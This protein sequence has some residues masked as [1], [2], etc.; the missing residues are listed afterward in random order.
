MWND[1]NGDGIL[2]VGEPGLL[3]WSVFIDQNSDGAQ[4]AG[5]PGSVTDGAGLYS[6]PSVPIGANLVRELPAIGWQPTAPGTGMQ[7][8]T[9][10]NGSNVA[11][12]NFGNQ[13]RT[14]GSIRGVA[15]ADYNKNHVR[16]VGEQG[17]AG[18]T[19]FLDTNDN[20]LLDPAEP[21]TLT[22]AD[23][24]YT[25]SLD[26]AGTY[27]FTHLA[28]GTYHVRE[29]VPALL[30]ATLVGDREVTVDLL[31]GEDRTGVNF[32][33]RFRG[34]EIHGTKYNDLNRNH[35]RDAGEPG[36]PGVTIYLD[37][38][39]DAVLNL[40]EP[41]TVTAADGSYS[42]VT[43]LNPGAY[44]LRE[45]IPTG[46][47]QTYPATTGGTLW[48]SGVS[49]AP[50]GNVSPTSITAVLSEFQSMHQNVSLTLP[51]TGALT[52]KIDVF[53]L[54]DD[55]GSFTDN[56]PIVRQRSRRSSAHCKHRCPGL[57]SDSASDASRNTRTSPRN[58]G[59][60]VRSS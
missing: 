10:P 2:G 26:E 46:W 5:E 37:M 18:I 59:R 52:N 30:S 32:A 35:Q 27:S 14:D 58:T 36:I 20:G 6:I 56:S 3:G 33:M 29:I 41:R 1:L 13:Q 47:S 23:L 9:V 51:S 49:N 21:Q 7:L 55:T 42:F 8:V 43:N 31:S 15:Y 16:D 38:N 45:V 39:R 53:L 25:P 19:V 12:V 4:N 54:F 60:G 44:V 48:P 28:A 24:F 50:I 34:N 11:G 40:D 57:T 22:S 17:L